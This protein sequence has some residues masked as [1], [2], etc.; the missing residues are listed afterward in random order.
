MKL[1]RLAIRKLD[2]GRSDFCTGLELVAGALL[3]AAAL[4][5]AAL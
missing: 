2:H 5:W 3:I 1:L 4:R